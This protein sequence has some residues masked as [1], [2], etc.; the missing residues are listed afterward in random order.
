M[1]DHIPALDKSLKELSEMTYQQ[2]AYEVMKLFLTDFTEEELFPIKEIVYT[3]AENC[4]GYGPVVIRM[5]DGSER[6][7]DFDGIEGKMSL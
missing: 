2:V 3:D 6:T 1:P 7:I 4:G 5:K